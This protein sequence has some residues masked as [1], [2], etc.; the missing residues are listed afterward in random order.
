MV[1]FPHAQV[2][3]VQNARHHLLAGHFRFASIVCT[4]ASC[5]RLAAGCGV[6]I[7]SLNRSNFSLSIAAAEQR[8]REF[9]V[10]LNLLAVKG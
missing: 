8:K 2:R 9:Y 6:T 1:A 7:V 3:T 4:S 10:D 5:A